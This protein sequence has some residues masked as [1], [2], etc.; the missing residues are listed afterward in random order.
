MQTALMGFLA[1]RLCGN[2][3]GEPPIGILKCKLKMES[4][5]IG[6]EALRLINARN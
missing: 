6:K 1:S 4:Q 5:T 2:E 3:K